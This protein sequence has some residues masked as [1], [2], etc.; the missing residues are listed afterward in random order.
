MDSL[1]DVAVFVR[2]VACNSFTRAADELELSRAVVSKYVARL[3]ERLGVRLLNRTT[4]R[5]AL[6]EAGA[7]L[8]EASRG[9]LERI[10]EAE[11]RVARL[12]REPQGRLK[13]N[14]PMSFGILQLSRVLPDFLARHPRIHVDLV[15]DDRLVDF[16]A[17]G[18]DVGIRIAELPDSSLVAKKVAPCPVVACAAPAY[19]A[20]QGEPA[21]PEDL[22][23]QECILYR[24]S[25]GANVWRFT[26]A[27]GRDIAVAVSGR[28]RMNNGIAMKEAALRGFGIILLP[29]FYVEQELR[30]GTLRRVLP[31]YRVP[32]LGMYAVYPQRSFVPPKVRA[33]VEFLSRS[34]GR[35]RPVSRRSA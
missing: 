13:V 2:V 22:A 10:D 33:F 5:L 11:E 9:A 18:F 23:T 31:H 21:T 14:A 8:F 4:R 30:D 16:L 25:A 20:E 1:T 26:A 29:T 7:E 17:D 24:Y 34:F 32:D 3:E 6:T 28:L 15:M 27:G 35:A 19:L 12:Q